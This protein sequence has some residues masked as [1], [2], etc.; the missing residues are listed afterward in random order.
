MSPPLA[1]KAETEA[2]L[3]VI[4][5]VPFALGTFSRSGGRRFAGLVKGDR[6]T[7]VA[8]LDAGV[9]AETVLGLLEDWPRNFSLLRKAADRV[10]GGEP[11]DALGVHPPVDLPR[12]IFCAGANYRQH[13]I[14]LAMAQAP[15]GEEKMTREERRAA[16]ARM[17]D[18]RAATGLPYAFTKIVSA[19]TGPFDPIILPRDVK[20]P[21]WELELAVVIGRPARRVSR[22]AAFDHVAGYTIANDITARERIYRADMRAIGTDWLSGKSAPSFMP[23]GPYFVPAAF[24][25]TPQDVRITLKLNGQVMQD[26]STS[27]M[28]FSIARLI[29]YV[30]SRVQLLPGDILSTG[31]PAGNG[32]HHGRFLKPGDVME[33][34]IAGLGYIRNQCIAETE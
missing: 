11:L 15:P 7:S 4:L 26:E 27:D 14:D 28:L 5:D 3:A 30:S 22:D 13:V 23:M 32:M 29:E 21:D 8:S 24:V 2:F 10:L 31:S 19:V 9:G 25:P 17:M 18:E 1:I 16:T 12:Q 6:V 34:S 33:G 20:E